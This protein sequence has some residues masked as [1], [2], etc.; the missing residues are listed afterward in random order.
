MSYNS[1]LN[2]AMAVYSC[3]VGYVLSDDDMYSVCQN[4]GS[5]SMEQPDCIQIG[6]LSLHTYIIVIILL[7][8]KIA[9]NKG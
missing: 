7:I 5:W 6:K 4:N 8:P 3:A 2:G 9:F 1:T